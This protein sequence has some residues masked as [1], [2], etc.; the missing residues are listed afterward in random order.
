MKTLRR[1]HLFA[2]QLSL[3][4]WICPVYSVVRLAR[5]RLPAAMAPHAVRASQLLSP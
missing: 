2:L 5:R 1:L 4:D 3:A